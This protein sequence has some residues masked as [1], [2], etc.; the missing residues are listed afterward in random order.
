MTSWRSVV[1]IR[2]WGLMNQV[3]PSRA[4][5]ST[6]ASALAPSQI[7]GCG[8]CIG[9]SETVASSSVKWEPAMLTPSSVQRRTTASRFSSSR[10][11]RSAWVV[12]KPLNSTSR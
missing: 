6:A 7:G 11:T 1:S 5:R 4:A 10:V 3:S 2:W 12:P 9:L 8:S